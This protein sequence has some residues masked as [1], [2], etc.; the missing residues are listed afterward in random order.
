MCHTDGRCWRRRTRSALRDWRRVL[1]KTA[2]KSEN[3]SSSC[4]SEA[5]EALI[6][7]PIWSGVTSLCNISIWTLTLNVKIT[8]FFSSMLIVDLFRVPFVVYFFRLKPIVSVKHDPF[9][10]WVWNFTGRSSDGFVFFVYINCEAGLNSLI[11]SHTVCLYVHNP[12]I[13]YFC[14]AA[15][16]V[17]ILFAFRDAA[18][19]CLQEKDVWMENHWI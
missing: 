12:H 16:S 8:C 5:H 7:L 6:K 15:V 14:K 9:K 3:I 11:K 17:W 4:R 19:F 10:L 18:S 13:V 2:V 1:V